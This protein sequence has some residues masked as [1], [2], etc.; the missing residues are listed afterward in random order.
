METYLQYRRIGNNIRKQLETDVEDVRHLKCVSRQQ[1]RVVGGRPV[2]VVEWDSGEDSFNPR[3]WPGIRK[4]RA[5]L[6][7]GLIAFLVGAVAPID[8]AVLPQAAKDFRV[9][10]VVESLAQAVFLIGFG[11]GALVFGPYSEVLGRS[12]SY[13]VPL[14]L[15]CIW[16]MASAL[17]P[18]IGAQTAFRFL[19]GFCGATPL[20]C[21][22][23]SLSDMY[24]PMEKTYMFPFF[25]ICGFGGP[26]IGPVMSAWIPQSPYLHTWRWSE[27]VAL[28]FSGVVFTITFLFMPET[29]APTL[30]SWKAKQLRKISGDDRYYAL[31]EIDRV[32]LTHRLTVALP[33][34]FVMAFYEPII[35]LITLYMSVLYIILFTFFGGYTFIFQETYGISQGLTNTIFVGIT[36][37]VVTGALP[38]PWIYGKTK[39]AQVKAEAEGRKQ[40]DPEVRLWN[41]MLGGAIAIPVSLLWMGWTAYPSVSI[42]SPIFASVVFGYGLITIFISSYM[43][44][45]DVYEAFAASAL[46]LATLVRYCCAGGMTMVG[47]PFYKNMGVHW[48]LTILACISA[49]L[50]PIPY[51]F[52]KYGHVLRKKSKFAT[53]RED[54]GLGKTSSRLSRFITS[55]EVAASRRDRELVRSERGE[56]Q[57]V[58]SSSSSLSTLGAD[59]AG[60]EKKKQ[61]EGN[62]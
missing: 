10:D 39:Q 9:S 24:T 5:T 50:T 27:W 60:E 23:G 53:T 30:L 25:A 57:N 1:T 46:T 55:D 7:V 4:F 58:S 45:I 15:F 54:Q 33:R 36:I 2:L 42:W 62:A 56:E 48:T 26:A 41:A 13:I 35:V 17:A 14:S 11:V 38:V 6:I 29:Y 3:N 19:A 61:Q 59:S 21:A 40:F 32:T 52:Y 31:H 43:Y 20:V 28:L 47:I 12:F 44:L 22:G 16:V 51:L 8:S 49:L 37:G 34:P 18:N